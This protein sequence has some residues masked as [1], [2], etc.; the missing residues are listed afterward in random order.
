MQ[1]TYDGDE[2][3]KGRERQ[4]ISVSIKETTGDGRWIHITGR[5]KNYLHWRSVN[6]NKG[7]C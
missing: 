2:C 3:N 1:G 4:T 7:V 6:I 5:G